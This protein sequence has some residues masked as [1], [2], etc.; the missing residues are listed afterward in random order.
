MSNPAR[1][2]GS[3]KLSGGQ[4]F[5]RTRSRPD[6][7]SAISGS[8]E[9]SALAVIGPMPGQSPGKRSPG[10]FSGPAHICRRCA[11]SLALASARISAVRASIFF[12]RVNQLIGQHIQ[13]FARGSW[14]TRLVT[15]RDQ[16]PDIVN[17]FG[18]DA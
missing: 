14:Q 8:V 9:I 13:G 1:V 10:S 11:A 16:A 18:N 3:R 7:T 17:A 15:G 6:L 4:F 5:P 12:L 2:S